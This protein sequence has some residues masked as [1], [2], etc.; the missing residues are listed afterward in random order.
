[1]KRTMGYLPYGAHIAQGSDDGLVK[2]WDVETGHGC[3]L[4]GEVFTRR[5]KY[6]V[7]GNGRCPN[8]IWECENWD[9][10]VHAVW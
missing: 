10:Q 9:L 7:G 2:I 3:D 8:S 6:R 4:F 1:M 5:V